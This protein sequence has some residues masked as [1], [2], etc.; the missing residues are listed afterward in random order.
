[1]RT[2]KNMQKM[3]GNISY[4][5]YSLPELVLVK[6]SPASCECNDHMKWSFDQTS[7]ESHNSH[8]RANNNIYHGAQRS[9]DATLW[10][11]IFYIFFLVLENTLRY[12]RQ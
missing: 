11:K 4:M 12:E 6:C 1:M 10:R 9:P 3:H 8:F 5:F 2:P 7:Q